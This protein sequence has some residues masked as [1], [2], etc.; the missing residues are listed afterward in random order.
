MNQ[1]PLLKLSERWFMVLLRLYPRD[2][3]DELGRSFVETYRDKARAALKQQGVVGLAGVWLRALRDALRSGPGERV[4]PAS[5]WRSRG[6]GRD[7]EL[8]MRRLRRAPGFVAAMIGTL[9]VGLGAF[10]IV[11]TVVQQILIAPMPYKD[12]DDLYFV[13]RDYGPLLDL[14]RGWLAGT[15]VTELQKSS[16][17]EYAAAL[18]RQLTTFAVRE[19]A[20]PIEISVMTTSPNLFDLLGVQPALGRGFR[21]EEVGPKRPPVV[22]LTHDLWNRLGADA[23]ILGTDV[24]LNGQPFTVI[25]VMPRHFA[26]MRNASLGPPQRADAYIPLNVNLA[27]TN[28]NGGSYAGLIR[29]RR[30]TSPEQAAAAVDAVGRAVDARDFKA[31]GLRLHSI[32]L[33]A[34]LVSEVRPAL[35]VLGASGVFL[36]LVLM[37]NLASVLLSRAAQREQEF[38]VS[39]AL[40]ADG[41]AVARATLVEGGLLGLI[42]GIAGTLAAVWG[43]RTLVAIAPLDL[44]RREAVTVDWSIAAVVIGL[45]ILFGLLAAAAAALWAARVSLASILAASAVRGGG[46]HGRMRQ[47]MVVVQVALSLVLLCAGALVV[48]S[49]ER[50]LVADPGFRPEG[51][52]TLRV[53]IPVQIVEQTADAIAIQDRITRALESLPGVRGVSAASAL[54][55]TASASQ[56]TI[57]IPGAPGNTGQAERDAPLVD[58]MGVRANYVEVMG[59]RLL[60]GRSLGVLS[61]TGV[62]E[63][64]IDRQLAEQFFPTGNPIGAKIPYGQKQEL[65]VV[66]VVEQAR[67]YDVHQDGRPQLYVRAEDWQYRTLNYVVRTERMP[68]SLVPEVRAA[69]R[70]VD[71]RLALADVRAMDAIVRDALR[72]QRV[73]AVLVAGFALA[74]LLLAAMGL[75]GVVA[76]SVSRRGHEF[77]VRLAL[78]A[79]PRSV[80]RMVLL[81]GARL[82]AIGVLIAVPGVYLAGDIVRGLLVGISPFDPPTLIAVALGLALVALIACYVPARRVL[83]IHPAQSLRQQ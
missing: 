26:F 63:A 18:G 17:V 5:A 10:A 33:K 4:Q 71:P 30:G 58:Y 73:S 32:G 41:F 11:F 72:E 16:V 82:V 55:L 51:V 47:S 22:V 65:T 44:P 14:K 9:T 13:W 59:I 36:V 62:R 50:L 76:G 49:F 64:L 27:D 68:E 79:E 67:M 40:G 19:G 74:G 48:R 21:P 28:P 70:Q 38:A 61:P 52:L 43:T 69:I 35:V 6:W 15:D 54:P 8:A 81:E 80:L 37:V 77:A 20:D 45:A 60:A 56:T 25:G 29:V 23:G 42:G 3:R 12:P 78:G 53:P 2:F 7:A 1:G 75:F 46:G 34:D 24:R 66:G 39:R 31:R 83:R 57:S